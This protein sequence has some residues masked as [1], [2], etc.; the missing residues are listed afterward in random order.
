MTLKYIGALG[1]CL[2]LVSGCGKKNEI[3]APSGSLPYPGL[4][5]KGAEGPLKET[6]KKTDKKDTKNLP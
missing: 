3:V 2:C 4:Y 5:P 6:D 1:I